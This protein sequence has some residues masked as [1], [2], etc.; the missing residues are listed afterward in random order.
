MY[1]DRSLVTTNLLYKVSFYLVATANNLFV[2]TITCPVGW[3]Y[4]TGFVLNLWVGVTWF[5]V[6]KTPFTP[7]LTLK[8]FTAVLYVNTTSF[9]AFFN[10]SCG[11]D[12]TRV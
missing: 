9:F 2:V 8:C 10:I 11:L 3:I 1:W 6:C 4:H 12:N 7:W 5:A